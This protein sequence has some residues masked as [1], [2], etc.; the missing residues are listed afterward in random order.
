[1]QKAWLNANGSRRS[2]TKSARKSC[3]DDIVTKKGMTQTAGALQLSNSQDAGVEADVQTNGRIY[4]NKN[5]G[6]V[7]VIDVFNFNSRKVMIHNFRFFCL[8]LQHTSQITE[9]HHQLF[10]TNG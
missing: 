10:I 8:M 2:I 5:T 9:L 1:M 6:D 7:L 3:H 4:A